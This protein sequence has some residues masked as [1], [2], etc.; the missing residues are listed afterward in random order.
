MIK[1]PILF[2]TSMVI[3]L[4][5]GRKSQTRRLTHNKRCNPSVWL[6][7]ADAWDAGERDHELWVREGFRKSNDGEI[8]FRA[9]PSSNDTRGREI[10]A[11]SASFWRPSIHLPRAASRLTLVVTDIARERLQNIG[12]GD[13]VREGSGAAGVQGFAEVWSSIHGVSAWRSNPT[14]IALT[15]EVKRR[16][17]DQH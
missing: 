12:D 15:F 1:R 8:V 2:S 16:N 5:E 13:A 11:G 4:L 17:I 14:V 6:R 10:G 9:N 3:A 7:L